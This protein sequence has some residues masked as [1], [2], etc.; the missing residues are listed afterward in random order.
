MAAHDT[1]EVKIRACETI[2]RYQFNDKLACAKALSAYPS[3]HFVQGAVHMLQRNDRMAVYG[4]VVAESYLCRRWLDSGLSK[5]Q[6]TTI[7]QDVLRNENLA[8][9]GFAHGLDHCVVLHPGTAVVSPNTMAT[10]VEAILGAAHVDGGDAAL[11]H[12]M[13]RLGLT[14]ALLEAVTYTL[15]LLELLILYF[16][17]LDLCLGPF[18]AVANVA[19]ADDAQSYCTSVHRFP[20]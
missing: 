4:D 12:M 1:V 7:V 2:V 6:W 14:H 17:S 8:A 16:G 5:A 13:E 10:T 9:V 3:A 19:L 15:A 11:G 20:I 18:I